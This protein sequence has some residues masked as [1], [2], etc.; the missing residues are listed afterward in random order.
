[1]VIF[2]CDDDASF[3]GAGRDAGFSRLNSGRA[4]SEGDRGEIKISSVLSIGL[5]GEL[6]NVA[7]VYGEAVEPCSDLVFLRRMMMSVPSGPMAT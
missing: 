5:A 7:T 4:E 3:S 2:A 1:M 6:P